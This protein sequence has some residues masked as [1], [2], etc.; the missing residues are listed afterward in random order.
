MRRVLT[1]SVR[2][3]YETKGREQFYYYQIW[4]TAATVFSSQTVHTGL[5]FEPAWDMTL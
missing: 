5:S 4:A 3:N 2:N 1:K